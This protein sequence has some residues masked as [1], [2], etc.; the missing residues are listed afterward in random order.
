VFLFA[1]MNIA[2]QSGATQ[3]QPETQWQ[4]SNSLHTFKLGGSVSQPSVTKQGEV[5]KGTSSNPLP[6]ARS[7]HAMAY[8]PPSVVA[9]LG[10]RAGALVMY[11][12]SNV[13]NTDLS[14]LTGNNNETETAQQLAGISWDTSTWLFDLYASQWVRLDTEGAAPP[15]LMYASMEAHGQQVRYGY[16]AVGGAH[17]KL[18]NDSHSL[19]LAY[20]VH[21]RA[22]WEEG[23]TCCPGR[24][25]Q[26]KSH[27]S[28]TYVT[29]ELPA[30]L[31]CA[32]DMETKLPGMRLPW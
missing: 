8:L 25:A 31:A 22:V 2:S 19:Y 20:L 32:F 12:G 23:C 27:R 28:G 13:T 14:S 4:P 21:L 10:M 16:T 6:A 17:Q 30:L 5:T 3:G 29:V 15:G 11:G 18:T 24:S 9:G 7:G 26:T 1:G